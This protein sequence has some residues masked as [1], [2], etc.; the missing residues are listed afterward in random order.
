MHV[1]NYAW[2]LPF[3]GDCIKDCIHIRMIEITTT[4]KGTCTPIA[5]ANHRMNEGEST[6]ARSRVTEVPHVAL[7]CKGDMFLSEDGITELL[8]S[9]ICK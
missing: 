7:S 3:A 8:G 1:A 9:I 2:M 5:T 4:G 6:L